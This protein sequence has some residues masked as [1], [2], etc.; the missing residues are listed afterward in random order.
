MYNIK[1]I[2]T[3]NELNQVFSFISKLFYDD[4]KEN[5]EYYYPMD[6][7]LEEMKKTLEIDNSFLLYI[8]DNKT[9]I[10]ALTGKNI[11]TTEQK[12]TIGVM[13]VD[14]EYR[15]KGIAKELISE[16]EK[17]CLKKNI[18]HID[19]GARFRACPLYLSMNYIPSLMIQVFGSTTIDDIK[20]IN[21]Y[22]FKEKCLWQDN[23]YGFIIYEIDEVREE[24]IKWFEKNIEKSHAQYI[25]E[26]DL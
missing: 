6:E 25:F 12:I 9:I 8:E 15:R 19:L 17:R 24:Y 13:A 1:T 20:R 11:N 7:R 3:E 16:F 10:A 22:N 26:K 23:N 5:S 21:T 2:K 14:K 18:K 4:A